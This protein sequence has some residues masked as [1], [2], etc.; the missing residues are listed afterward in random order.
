MPSSH[1]PSS[2]LSSRSTGAKRA[3]PGTGSLSGTRVA[4]LER[5]LKVVQETIRAN[6]ARIAALQAQ[7]DHV[8]AKQRGE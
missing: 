8:A 7:V 4:S 6:M 1:R 5:R 3:S 2:S